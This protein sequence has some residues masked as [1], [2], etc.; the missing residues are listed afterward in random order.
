M[1]MNSL[2]EREK[3][4]HVGIY[5]YDLKR[6]KYL[7]EMMIDD[8]PRSVDLSLFFQKEPGVRESDCQV[9]YHEQFLSPDGRTALGG[10][11]QQGDDS[12]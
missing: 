7:L 10:F 5:A 3:G 2:S 9:P 11:P 4:E 12:R 8:K 6:N 1:E